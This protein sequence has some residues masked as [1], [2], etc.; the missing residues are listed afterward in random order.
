MVGAVECSRFK[1]VWGEDLGAGFCRAIQKF[2]VIDNE[3]DFSARVQALPYLGN[4]VSDCCEITMYNRKMC[5]K[6]ITV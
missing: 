1:R 4:N 6:L 5:S 3:M 2:V